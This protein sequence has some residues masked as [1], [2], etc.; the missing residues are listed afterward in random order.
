MNRAP[1]PINSILAAG[2]HSKIGVRLS[3]FK[4]SADWVAQGRVVS[5][6]TITD[7]EKSS[8]A[9]RKPPFP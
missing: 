6:R 9:T 5:V 4:D 1:Q 8:P 7:P 3:R 2:E